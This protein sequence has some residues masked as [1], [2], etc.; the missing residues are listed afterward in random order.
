V[1]RSDNRNGA[2]IVYFGPETFMPV[3]SALAAVVGVLLLLGRKVAAYA[4]AAIRFVHRLMP[5][6]KRG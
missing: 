3:A 6:I 5:K 4:R 1:R 2:T